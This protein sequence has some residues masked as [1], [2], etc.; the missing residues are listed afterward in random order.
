MTRPLGS[1]SSFTI[2][3]RAG[4]SC[5]VRVAYCDSSAYATSGPNAWNVI[6]SGRIEGRINLGENAPRSLKGTSVPDG[7]IVQLVIELVA[8]GNPKVMAEES[9]TYD[10]DSFRTATYKTSGTVFN[11]KVER[12]VRARPP[13]PP[14]PAPLALMAVPASEDTP[15]LEKQEKQTEPSDAVEESTAASSCLARLLCCS[16]A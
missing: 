6:I 12:V 3:H 16:T 1:V 15:L 10:E 8:A 7:A 9:W 2:Q 4:Y 14:P 11:P 13:P 5:Y